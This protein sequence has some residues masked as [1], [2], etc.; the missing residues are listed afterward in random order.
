MKNTEPVDQNLFE[1]ESEARKPTKRELAFQ[2]LRVFVAIISIGGLLYIS[3]IYQS[4]LYRRT[5][6]N[7]IQQ[8]VK[9]MLNAET[10]T[11]PL[12]VFVFVN[13]K[14]GSERSKKDV[15]RLVENA[16]R[17]WKQAEIK[18]SIEKIVFLKS[19]D[20]EIEAFLNN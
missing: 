12:R 5:P 18:L 9:S 13:K 6:A 1:E 4:L 10:I 15:E 19:N 20:Q 8:K 14:S 11:V 2:Y 7:V 3:G 17:I 16:S